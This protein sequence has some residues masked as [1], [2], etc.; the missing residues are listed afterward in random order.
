MSLLISNIHSQQTQDITPTLTVE[1]QTSV[2]IGDTVTLI[3]EVHQ[4]T[5]WEF[6][7]RRSPQHDSTEPTGTKTITSVKISDGGEYMCIA[8]NK[9]NPHVYTQ[10]SEPITLTVHDI[11][12]TLTVKPQTSVFIG[13]KVTLICE[14]YQSTGWEFIF[15]NPSNTK[16]TETT[17]TKTIRSVQVSDGGEY[18]CIARRKENPQIYTQYSEPITVTV[19]DKPTL[20]VHHQT[21]V[22]IGDSV[23][24]ICEVHQST[25]WKFIF[26]KYPNTEF[27]ETTGT[28]TIRSVQ[29]SDGGE[30]RCQARKENPHVYTAYSDSVIV[31]VQDVNPTLSVQPQTSVFIEDTVTLICEVHQSTGWEFIFITPSKTESTET[32]GTKIIRSVQVSDGGEYKC[33]A[34]RGNPQ[35]YTQ[36]SK[37]ITVTVQERPTPQVFVWPDYLLFRG[38]TV[39]LT[40]V[41]NGGGVNSWQY[42]W[43]KDSIIQQNKLQYYTRS[44]IESDAGKYTCKGTEISGSRYSHISNAVTLTVSGESVSPFSIYSHI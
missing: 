1:P 21:S 24:L 11:T 9:E 3:C 44:V 13:D 8:R 33:R 12:P 35:V 26:I 42:S 19:K 2:F 4:S 5:E 37:P 25:G 10:Y 28:K 36:Y 18:K 22:F 39:N 16:S 15:I 43:H 14:V 41:I 40:C 27:T 30:Y 7:F 23:T 32:T 29:V 6:I 34:G 31:T 38:E 17:G 20:T